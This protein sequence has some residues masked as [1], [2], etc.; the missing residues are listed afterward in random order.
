MISKKYRKMH[1]FLKY[2]EYFQ[3][4]FHYK[5]DVLKIW[6]TYEIFKNNHFLFLRKYFPNRKRDNEGKR[7]FSSVCFIHRYPSVFDVEERYCYHRNQGILENSCLFFWK[8]AIVLLK[9][10]LRNRLFAKLKKII[11]TYNDDMG[12]VG[13]RISRTTN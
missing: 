1:R 8:S 13:C 3:Q 10:I 11:I 7:D 12:I 2:S 6:L 4:L 9:E 5:I